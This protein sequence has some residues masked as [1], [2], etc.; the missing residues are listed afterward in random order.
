MNFQKISLTL[1]L[2]LLLDHCAAFQLPHTQLKSTVPG[3]DQLQRY[4]KLN[5]EDLSEISPVTINYCN[6]DGLS[7]QNEDARTLF[8]VF[9]FQLKNFRNI[10]LS[11]MVS[12]LLFSH[13]DLASAVL[14]P[15][16]PP[17][18][19]QAQMRD[20]M[21]VAPIRGVWRIRE[22]ESKTAP[23]CKGQL[24]FDG[25]VDQMG[26]TVKYEGCNDRKG[27]GKW[28]LKPIRIQEGKVLYSARWK[29]KFTDGTTLIYVGDLRTSGYV[30][31]KPDSTM[32]GEILI[33]V[34]NKAG[35]MSEKSSGG[36]FTADILEI[37][38]DTEKLL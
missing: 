14:E 25:F 3:S 5:K 6:K 12:A 24:K 16:E 29:L 11:A 36:K 37:S 30:T 26:G 34:T 21:Q 20:A 15:L 17:V 13:S 7:T 32:S 8:S 10:I 22:Y 9:D 38:T 31:E 27:S 28:L 19:Y 4:A 33:P 2:V 1:L 35:I 23:L 18:S